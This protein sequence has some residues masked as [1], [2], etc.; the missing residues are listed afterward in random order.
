MGFDISDDLSGVAI[1]INFPGVKFI[2]KELLWFAE[3][4]LEY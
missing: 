2:D 3:F 1:E 4:S